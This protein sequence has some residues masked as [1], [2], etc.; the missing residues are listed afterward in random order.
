MG[1]LGF[2]DVWTWVAID[3]DSKLVM[4][5][6][7]GKRNAEYA[8]KFVDDLASRLR[9]RIQLTT[10]G[11]T[12]YLTA[13]ERAVYSAH[14]CLL[15]ENGQPCSCHRPALHVL[16]LC[17]GPSDPP[18]DSSH[19][20]RNLGSCVVDSGDFGA[21]RIKLDHYHPIENPC[22]CLIASSNIMGLRPYWLP[23]AWGT[24]PISKNTARRSIVSTIRSFTS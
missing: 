13:V 5:W 17:Q 24:I 4:S 3:A 16:Q 10:D 18:S 19:A 9:N 8:R 21:A 11:L 14:E 7:V 15:Q 23:Y 20:G 6:L 12:L 2:G 1:K 22:K